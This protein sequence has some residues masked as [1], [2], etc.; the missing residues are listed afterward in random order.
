MDQSAVAQAR[1]LSPRRHSTEASNPQEL[2]A[3]QLAH[4]GIDADSEYG[5]ALQQAAM[6]YSIPC[7]IH[8]GRPIKVYNRVVARLPIIPCLI[9]LPRCFLLIL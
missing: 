8:F 7:K 6:Q 1:L 5:Q 3:E 2:A 9:M 4:F